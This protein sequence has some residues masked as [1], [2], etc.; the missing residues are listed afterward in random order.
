MALTVMPWA[1]PQF[2]DDDG[3][4]LATGSLYTYEAG[5]TTDLA[6]YQDAAGTTPHTN[7]IVLNAQGRPP[8][9]VGIF[10]LPQ[11]YRFVL[12][13]AD[14][15]TVWDRDNVQ[16]QPSTSVDVD[17]PATAG[18]DIDAGECVYMSDGQGSK[19]AGR[20]Y[21]ADAGN[22]YESIEPVVGFVVANIA[23]GA[24]GTV[25][26]SG[27]VTGLAGLSPGSR[28]YIS[29]T[30]GALTATKP[31]NGRYVGFAESTT[32]LVMQANPAPPVPSQAEFVL[33]SQVFG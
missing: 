22:D 21:L 30:G 14:G 18:E 26:V 23:S 33:A 7:P 25:R 1:V 10:L 20:W 28:Y 6:T 2:L 32:A 15:V 31:N 24:A 27:R 29:A 12:K 3:S 13:D 17:I 11:T 9:D 4:V 8:S 16:A 19:T 5:T